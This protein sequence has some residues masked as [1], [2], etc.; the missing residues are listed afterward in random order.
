MIDNSYFAGLFDGEG[1]ITFQM[2]GYIPSSLHMALWNTHRPVLLAMQSKYGGSVTSKNVKAN[3][4]SQWGWQATGKVGITFL[5]EV[6]PYLIIKK[7]QAEIAF[8][9]YE[10]MSSSYARTGV[11]AGILAIR[12][13]LAEKLSSLKKVHYPDGSPIVALPDTVDADKLL[14]EL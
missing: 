5:H 4:L 9:Y 6:Y 3:R 2:R 1:C 13:M 14:D 11:P 7:E 12:Q 10:T 8:K